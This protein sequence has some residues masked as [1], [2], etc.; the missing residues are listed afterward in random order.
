MQYLKLSGIL[1]HIWR[2]P[3]L[4]L[5]H[6]FPRIETFLFLSTMVHHWLIKAR[7]EANNIGYWYDISAGDSD[8][9]VLYR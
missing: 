5:V 3:V 8:V 6:I 2:F 1:N 4:G 7:Y 9:K